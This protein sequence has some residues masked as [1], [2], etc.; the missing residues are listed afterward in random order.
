M[1][2]ECFRMIQ[3]YSGLFREIV[4]LQVPRGEA[5]G[6]LQVRSAI[7]IWGAP[8]QT[9]RPFTLRKERGVPGGKAIWPQWR[10]SQAGRQVATN[11]CHI[12]ISSLV[13]HLFYPTPNQNPPYITTT[14]PLYSPRHWSAGNNVPY[15]LQ[16]AK[17]RIIQHNHTIMA[18]HQGAR[19]SRFFLSAV[20]YKYMLLTRSEFKIAIHLKAWLM[21]EILTLNPTLVWTILKMKLNE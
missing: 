13:L 9:V 8:G 3:G 10:P 21:S 2:W 4:F 6:W 7:C 12:S 19:V 14:S 11:I 15:K 1:I 20:L 17:S 16:T 5:R 18:C